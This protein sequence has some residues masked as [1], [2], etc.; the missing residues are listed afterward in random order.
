MEIDRS[1][2]VWAE[3]DVGIAAPIGVVWDVLT[4]VDD[5]PRWFSLGESVAIDGPVAPGATL[6][7]KGRGTGTI[8]ATIQTVEQPDVLA[9]S[10]RMFGISSISVWRLDA[11]GDRT[12]VVKGES[13]RGFPVRV[14]R[15]SLQ[16]KLVGFM[17]AWLRD[18]KVEAELRAR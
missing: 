11:N 14:M 12:R 17:D 10:S 16:R 8:T 15:R 4:N 9:W 3:Q 6:Q 5:I 1:A 2:P 7:M 18:L 13:M